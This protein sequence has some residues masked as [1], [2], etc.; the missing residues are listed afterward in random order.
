MKRKTCNGINPVVLAIKAVGS[1][2]A[3]ASALTPPV[4]RQAIGGWLKRGE[5]PPRRVPEVA[6]ATGI[7][8][9]IL[10]P[11]FTR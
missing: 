5:I 1:Q 8:K 9:H 3:L 2:D 4:S 11:L 10:S 7:P 6:K